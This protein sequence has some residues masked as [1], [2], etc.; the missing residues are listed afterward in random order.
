MV[1]TSLINTKKKYRYVANSILHSLEKF[2]DGKMGARYRILP[3]VKSL[4]TRGQSQ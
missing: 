2:E 3:R 4:Q 1:H